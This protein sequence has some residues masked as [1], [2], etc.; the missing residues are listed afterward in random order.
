MDGS[1][2]HQAA[3]IAQQVLDEWK[4]CAWGTGIAGTIDLTDEIKPVTDQLDRIASA[5]DA[6]AVV[7]AVFATAFPDRAEQFTRYTCASVGARLYRDFRSAG[8]L[9]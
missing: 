5:N 8:L 7:A 2:Q 1:R 6:A 9:H 4:P 3:V